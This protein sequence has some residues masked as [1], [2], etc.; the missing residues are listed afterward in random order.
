[1]HQNV[2]D[3]AV[4]IDG[5]PQVLP[6]TIDDEHLVEMPLVPRLRAATPQLVGILLPELAAPPPRPARCRWAPSSGSCRCGSYPTHGRPDRS[7]RSR[8]VRS[9]PCPTPDPT[10]VWSPL[11]T[12][13]PDPTGRCPRHSPVPTADQPTRPEPA[14]AGC[15]LI[16]HQRSRSSMVLPERHHHLA[17][18]L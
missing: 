10:P 3:G 18:P 7:C 2:Q 1:L 5:P 12:T 15:D 9:A 16:S 13:H 11:T 14:N 4:L 6:L 8:G 17:A